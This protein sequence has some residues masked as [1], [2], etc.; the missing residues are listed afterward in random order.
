MARG[1]SEPNRVPCR[2]GLPGLWSV[3]MT[4]GVLA[5]ISAGCAARATIQDPLL[6]QRIDEYMTVRREA[7]ETVGRVEVTKD[8]RELRENVAGLAEQIQALRQGA[9]EGDRRSRAT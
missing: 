1:Q 8:P 2:G 7:V 3:G 4:L 5:L 6:A 9:R